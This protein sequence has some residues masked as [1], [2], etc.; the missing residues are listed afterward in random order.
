MIVKPIATAARLSPLALLLNPWF[1]LAICIWTAGIAVYAHEVGSESGRDKERAMWLRQANATKDAEIAALAKNGTANAALQTKFNQTNVK[2][3]T[4]HETEVDKNRSDYSA[5]RVAADRAGGLR[6]P[7]PVRA[8]C[9]RPAASAQVADAVK[10]DEEAASTVR[11]PRE[12]EDRLWTRAEEAD[13]LSAQIRA[14]QA[15]VTENGFY[16]PEPAA[17]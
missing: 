8:K 12:L 7:S 2:V 5:D 17:P 9:D 3:S 13:A 4:G 16:G 11:L 14:M 10:P 1:W 6:I 15:W